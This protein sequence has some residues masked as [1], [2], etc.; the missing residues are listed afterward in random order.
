MKTVVLSKDELIEL[1]DQR[2]EYAI[3][4]IDLTEK[5]KKQDDKLLTRHDVAQLFGVTLV[6]VNEWCKKEILITHRMNS[7]VYFYK[8]EVMDALNSRTQI[9]KR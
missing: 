7:R 3:S 8:S 1:L 4:K 2:L 9:N 6:T 5:S